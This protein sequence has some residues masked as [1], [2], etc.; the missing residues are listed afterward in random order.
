MDEW[1]ATSDRDNGHTALFY[2]VDTLLNRK[3]PLQKMLGMLNL[4]ATCTSKVALIEW[5]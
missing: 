4:A 5:L 3:T 1:L 2:C